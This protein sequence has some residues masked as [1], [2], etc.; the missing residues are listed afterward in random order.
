MIDVAAK[1]DDVVALRQALQALDAA[2]MEREAAL[3]TLNREMASASSLARGLGY[4]EAPHEP[5]PARRNRA[6]ILLYHRVALVQPDPAGLCIAPPVFRAHMQ[7]IARS[8]EPMTLEALTEAML[9]DRLPPQAV[10][11]TLD[12]GYL[13]SLTASDILIDLHLPA[14]FFVNSSAGG[15][16]F[17]DSLA[18][19]FL[20]PHAIPPQLDL[21]ILGAPLRLSCASDT[22]RCAAFDALRE[23]GFP[24]SSDGRRELIAALARWCSLDLAPRPSHRMLT[25]AEM[26]E[27]ASRPGH[28]IGAHTH[29][30]LFLPVQTRSAKIHEISANRDY[31]QALIGRPV[32]AF[33]FPYGAFDDETVSICRGL[34]FQSATTVTG[35]A[36][37]PWNDP[38]LMPRVEI[39]ADTAA[40]FPAFVKRVLS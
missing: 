2:R 37:R 16:T 11:I 15:E 14:T 17:L 5:Q 10:A 38:L 24:L 26:R 31:L 34:G 35:Q 12:D 21:T 36:V 25:P 22:G 19:V 6:M 23:I 4:H 13:D 3:E 33:A 29:D 7:H 28:A 8:C 27:L 20:G 39:R 30:H 32:S 40:D 1:R 18:R 9:E